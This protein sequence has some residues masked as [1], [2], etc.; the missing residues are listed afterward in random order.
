MKKLGLGIIM[1]GILITVF[2]G[3]NFVTREKVVDIG[4]V[5]ITHD[6]NHWLQW[7]PLLGVGV[8]IV[9]A[10]VMLSPKKTL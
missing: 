8:I 2:T 6:K 7:S 5:Q 1:I 9:G 4:A 3:F 10:F